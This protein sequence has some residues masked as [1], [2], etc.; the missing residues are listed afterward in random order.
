VKHCLTSEQL[1]QAVGCLNEFGA[2]LAKIAAK[3]LRKFPP[4]AQE[5]FWMMLQDATSLYSPYVA[6]RIDKE[7]KA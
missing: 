7:L 1:D 3:Q 2:D 5:H 6:N 4:E